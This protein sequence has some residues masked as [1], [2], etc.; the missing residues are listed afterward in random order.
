MIRE[1]A[2]QIGGFFRKPGDSGDLELGRATKDILK[3]VGVK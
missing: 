1:A 3:F 2:D